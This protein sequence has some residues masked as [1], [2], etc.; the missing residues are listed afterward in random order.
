VAVWS[1]LLTSLGGSNLSTVLGMRRL[2]I[3]DG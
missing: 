3:L 1:K 2:V